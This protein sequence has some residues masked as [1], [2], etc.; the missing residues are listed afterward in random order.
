MNFIAQ[1]KKS[2]KD[3]RIEE[4]VDLY[5]FRPVAFLVVKSIHRLPISPNQI[6][7]LGLVV[8]VISAYF[9]AFGTTAGFV[10]GGVLF[11]IYGVID[12]CDG[13]L[14]RMNGTGSDLGKVI[15]GVVDYLVNICVYVSLIVG[16]QRSDIVMP[17]GPIYFVVLSGISTIIHGIVYDYYLSAYLKGTSGSKSDLAVDIEK[18]NKKYLA[19]Q[20]RGGLVVK[21]ILVR[22]Y[23][24][25]LNIQALNDEKENFYKYEEFREKNV[26]IL[27]LWGFIG[28]STHI[29]FLAMAFILG[30]P[31]IFFIYVFVFANSWM[32]FVW[33]L[34]KFTNYRFAQVHQL[35]NS[36]NEKRC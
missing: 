15:D 29:F 28:P 10:F 25:Y 33:A 26:L 7:L 20:R 31:M 12:D 36:G 4:R 11:A 3:I 34:Q 5:L 17:I 19:Y 27:K 8:G 9:F 21:K 30:K 18:F 32:L 35:I 1:Y 2:L 14:A 13:M 23:L 6:T 16:L 24:G 22:V